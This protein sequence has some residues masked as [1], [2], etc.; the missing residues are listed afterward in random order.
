MNPLQVTLIQSTLAWESPKESRLHFDHHLKSI[1]P[2]TDLVVLPEMFTTGFSMNPQHVAEPFDATSMETLQW[3]QEWAHQLDAVI[4][5]SVSVSEQGKYYNRLLW[6]RPDGTFSHYDKRHTFTFAGEHQIYQRGNARLIESW[7]GWKICPLIC[8]D[9]RFPVWSRNELINGKPSYDVLIYV[10]SWP[11]V[12]R[13]PWQKLLTARAIENQ[14]FVVGVN[15]TGVDGNSHTYSGDSACI[16]PKGEYL[17]A[18]PVGEEAVI[19]CTL[20]AND[21]LDFR[22]KFPVL[23]DA[24]SFHIPDRH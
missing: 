2:K 11:E 13:S 12:R 1:T 5:G 14:C 8:Y 20:N 21:L 15:R 16:D 4:T 24:D 9:L 22:Q 17:A 19:T 18:L 10:A 7:R 3:M 23:E 6:V